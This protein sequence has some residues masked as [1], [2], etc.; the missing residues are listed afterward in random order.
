MNSS[1]WL[2][3]LLCGIFFVLIFA[4]LA[5]AI[6]LEPDPVQRRARYH[7][8]LSPLFTL[9]PLGLYQSHL[10]SGLDVILVSAVCSGGLAWFMRERRAAEQI[11][12]LKK[13]V[14][15]LEQMAGGTPT[16]APA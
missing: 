6:S 8:L 2:V 4:G 7:A 5:Y 1:L 3:L 11:A 15:E 9:I 13:R 14:L 10:I 16:T 12:Q